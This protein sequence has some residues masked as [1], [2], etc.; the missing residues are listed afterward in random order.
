MSQPSQPG[1]QGGVTMERPFLDPA[2]SQ[3]V[4]DSFMGSMGDLNGQMSGL[5]GS[6][7]YAGAFE[8]GKLNLQNSVNQG[9]VGQFNYSKSLDPLVQAQLSGAHQETAE[10]LGAKNS[11]IA[12]QMRRAPGNNQALTAAMQ[13][14]SSREAALQA[15]P[16]RNQ[17]MQAQTAMDAQKYGLN[18]QGTSLNNQANLNAGN[19]ANN[20]ALAGRQAEQSAYQT[21]LGAMGQNNQARLSALS[22]QLQ[23]AGMLGQGMINTAGRGQT[24][25]TMDDLE[26]L[27]NNPGLMGTAFGSGL[28]TPGM[29]ENAGIT[30]AVTPGQQN[31]INTADMLALY[32]SPGGNGGGVQG[33]VRGITPQ[34]QQAWFDG[35]LK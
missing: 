34:L 29:L 7:Q 33:G 32:G 16:Y 8:P 5:P 6:M 9:N 26:R 18:L 19:F 22:P 10:A 20:A 31:M 12:D 23:W 13:A 30:G 4:Q 3:G 21:N 14:D 17:A 2:V 1:P 27:R 25:F 35:R 28:M 15:N 24:N 11:Q